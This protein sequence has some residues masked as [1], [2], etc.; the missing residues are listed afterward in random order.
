MS[1]NGLV[2]I[3]SNWKLPFLVDLPPQKMVDFPLRKLFH[4]SKL[5]QDLARETTRE[6]LRS[7]RSTW[8]FGDFT[9]ENGWFYQEKP[10][11]SEGT[12]KWMV[13]NSV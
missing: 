12:T 6:E 2:I 11:E 4:S 9:G 13:Y 8:D 1:T 5:L 10:W 7:V 3:H